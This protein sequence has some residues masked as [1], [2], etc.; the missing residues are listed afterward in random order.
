MKKRGYKIY[1]IHSDHI[2]YNELIYLPVLRSNYLSNHTLIFPDSLDNKDKYFKDIIHDADLIVAEMSKPD[3]TFN[4][5][6]KEAVIAKKP[7][8]GLAN[9]NNGFDPKYQKLIN[10][11]VSYNNEEELRNFVEQFVKSYEGKIINGKLDNTVILG[12]LN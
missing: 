2:D 8:L 3:L 1:F 12:V 7:I 4:M 5:E 10:N 6:V 11:I 9:V